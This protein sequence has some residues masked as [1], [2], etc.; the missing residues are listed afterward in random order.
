MFKDKSGSLDTASQLDNL[1][2]HDCA[3]VC[4]DTQLASAKD[5]TIYYFLAPILGYITTCCLKTFQT[6][7]CRDLQC[8]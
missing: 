8:S 5:S 6:L 7:H 2:V 4:L 1:S 3:A